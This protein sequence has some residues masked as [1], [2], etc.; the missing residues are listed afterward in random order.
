MSSRRQYLAG[1]V[2]ALF[3]FGAAAWKIAPRDHF[4]GWNDTRRRE[5]LHL[6]INNVRF[7]TL[8]W[9]HSRN[10]AP[11]SS[12]WCPA[13]SPTTGQTSTPI[14]RCCWR[15]SWR[16][17]VCRN[18]LQGGQLD[19]RG[20][21]PGPR[22]ARLLSNLSTCPQGH[23]ALPRRERLP[24]LAVFLSSHIFCRNERRDGFAEY[25]HEHEGSLG[26]SS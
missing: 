24:A 13:R 12:V 3:G 1:S 23:L 4:I 22:Q 18:L 10:L 26:P 11:V 8:P 21:D 7:L 17:P 2:L 15:P 25:A 16:S 6:V 9:V 19:L 20:S 14:V 5:H